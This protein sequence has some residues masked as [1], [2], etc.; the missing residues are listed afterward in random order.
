MYAFDDLSGTFAH[1]SQCVADSSA[2]AGFRLRV[3]FASISQS[4]VFLASA[5]MNNTVVGVK[6][7]AGASKL[8]ASNNRFQGANNSVR[9]LA[10]CQ[11]ADNGWI[12]TLNHHSAD[13]CIHCHTVAR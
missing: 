6:L 12:A 13:Y 2:V 11:G 3:G 7:D 5:Q 1:Y 10:A 8:V 4:S 9:L